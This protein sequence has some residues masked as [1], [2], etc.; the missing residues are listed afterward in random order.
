MRCTQH[1]HAHHLCRRPFAT[2]KKADLCAFLHIHHLNHSHTRHRSGPCHQRFPR[3][4][5]RRGHWQPGGWILNNG[6]AR[7]EQVSPPLQKHRELLVGQAP[8][9]DVV[10]EQRG[11]LSQDL[12]NAALKALR[13]AQRGQQLVGVHLPIAIVVENRKHQ[14]V[15]VLAL[16]RRGL[17]E[18]RKP[19]QKLR[20]V[21][22]AI[23]VGVEE[24][25][26]RSGHGLVHLSQSQARTEP[27]KAELVGILPT[28]LL[29]SPQQISHLLVVELEQP[30]DLLHLKGLLHSRAHRRHAQ[31]EVV[32]AVAGARHPLH[33]S[34]FYPNRLRKLPSVGLLLVAGLVHGQQGNCHVVDP[35]QQQVPRHSRA[36]LTN[37]TDVQM[38]VGVVQNHGEYTLGWDERPGLELNHALAVGE[39]ALGED[40]HRPE[41]HSAATMEDGIHGGLLRRRV[42]A[43]HEQALRRSGHGT[44]SGHRFHLCFGEEA[45]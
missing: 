37:L 18:E 1:V 33:G 29:K 42:S 9:A 45:A 13:G 30:V 31:E 10:G 24:P 16:K 43:V 11:D 4:C 25:E 15:A 12:L 22:V 28:G 40:C 35:L 36:A 41:P 14:L 17:R 5:S 32:V 19:R 2:Q 38:F 44:H 8:A 3:Q 34:H 27:L 6:H 26:H 20:E 23:V 7:A 39:R 21:D